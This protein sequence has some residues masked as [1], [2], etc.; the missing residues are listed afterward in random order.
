MGS[1]R[2]SII[3][4]PRPVQPPATLGTPSTPSTAKIRYSAGHVLP[5]VIPE[6]AG[7]LSPHPGS[8]LRTVASAPPEGPSRYSTNIIIR[9]PLWCLKSP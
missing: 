4:R 9:W 5:S 8:T 6:R 7:A 1:L 3:K 2:T